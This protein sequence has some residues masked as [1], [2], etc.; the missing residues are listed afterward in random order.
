MTYY[1]KLTQNQI[2]KLQ[3]AHNN[4]TNATLEFASNKIFK[5]ENIYN[6]DKIQL[7]KLKN[8]KEKKS[9]VRIEIRNSQIKDKK[10]GFLPLLFA[11]IGAASALVGGVSAIY[12]SVNDKK[13]KNA[14]IQETIRHNKAIENKGSGLKKKKNKSKK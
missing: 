9:G 13:F 3:E 14:M 10:G 8:A 1:F 11:G 5:G 2:K 6:L 12:N 7:D 4:N